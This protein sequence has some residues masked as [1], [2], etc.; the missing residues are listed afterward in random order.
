MY[1]STELE[2]AAKTDGQ[3]IERSLLALDGQKVCQGLGGMEVTA[4]TCVDDR[5]GGNLCRNVGS[6]FLGMTHSDDIGISAYHADG[7]R[8]AFALGRRA[9]RRIGEAE[10]VTAEAHHSGGEAESGSRGRLEEERA[11]N[12]A[13]AGFRV[14]RGIFNNI[15]CGRDH[16][17]DF[18][19]GK[20]KNVNQTSHV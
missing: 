12:L 13:L 14:F 10:N 2:V 3:I 15:F 16:L 11:E 1:G 20:F 17:V 9:A 5:H 8:N 19:S 4:V 6:A 18:R 7:I